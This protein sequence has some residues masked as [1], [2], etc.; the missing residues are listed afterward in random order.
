M[1]DYDALE[2]RLAAISA[3]CVSSE[4]HGRILLSLGEDVLTLMQAGSD[5]Y[6]AIRDLRAERDA[7]RLK[8]QQASHERDCILEDLAAMGKERDA[9]RELRQYL[10]HKLGKTPCCKWDVELGILR[11]EWPC[12]CGL[13]AALA[14]QE[15][16]GP[17]H[18]DTRLRVGDTVIV[19]GYMCTLIP[20]G[21]SPAS[22]EP[23]AGLIDEDEDDGPTTVNRS[24]G[25]TD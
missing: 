21:A 14:A 9:L 19:R 6:D 13:D 16:T 3:G 24:Y 17:M 1:T 10:R 5:A 8:R 23:I 4:F 7:D 15:P 18:V 2:K 22:F 20:S 25:G 12:S 11:S